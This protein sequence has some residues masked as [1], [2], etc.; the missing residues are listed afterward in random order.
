V[1]E[2]KEDTSISPKMFKNQKQVLRGCFLSSRPEGAVPG[3]SGENEHKHCPKFNVAL[4]RQNT[5]L[6]TR[7]RT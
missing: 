2:K 6:V 3:I 1:A 4:I 7:A 5:R